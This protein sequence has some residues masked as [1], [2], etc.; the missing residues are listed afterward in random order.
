MEQAIETVKALGETGEMIPYWYF[1]WRDSS[2]KEGH[3]GL[4]DLPLVEQTM[5]M[6]LNTTY[7]VQ[8]NPAFTIEGREYVMTAAQAD[9]LMDHDLDTSAFL[10][11]AL[12]E[13]PAIFALD[14]TGYQSSEEAYKAFIAL[15][16]KE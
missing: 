8:D 12:G 6:V 10:T 16:N 14:L 5:Q 9:Y 13:K 15:K 3:Y 11:Q 7:M 1:S 4:N 2:G